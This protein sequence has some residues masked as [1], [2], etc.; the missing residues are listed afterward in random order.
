MPRVTTKGRSWHFAL[1]CDDRTRPETF[2][3]RAQ[4][5]E[6]PDIL[7]RERRE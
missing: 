2:L 1:D 7:A 4:R 5:V 6:Q 3:P